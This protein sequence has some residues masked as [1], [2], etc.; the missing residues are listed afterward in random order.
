MVSSKQ[1]DIENILNAILVKEGVR[2]AMLIQPADY[3]EA[4]GTDKKTSSIVNA[5]IKL[6]PNLVSSDDYQDYQGT[7]ISKQSYDGTDISLNRMGEILGYPC[8]SDFETLNREEPL[9]KLDLKVS[10][11]G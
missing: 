4:T 3:G 2:P 11:I 6:F 10:Y 9:F 1:K 7:I 5:I 8:F